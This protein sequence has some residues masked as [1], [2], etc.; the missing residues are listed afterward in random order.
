MPY[1]QVHIGNTKQHHGNIVWF[2]HEAHS[3]Q[4]GFS[5]YSVLLVTAMARAL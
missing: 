4:G 1:I 3:H 2:V 5:S